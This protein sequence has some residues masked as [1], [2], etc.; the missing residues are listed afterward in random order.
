MGNREIKRMI[1]FLRRSKKVQ[2]LFREGSVE[3][4]YDP[5]MDMTHF[6]NVV[7]HKTI[8]CKV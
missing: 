5:V 2:D 6:I 4:K 1:E 7:N 8:S 3:I